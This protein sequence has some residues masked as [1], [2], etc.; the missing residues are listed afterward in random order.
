MIPTKG[1]WDTIAPRWDAILAD[2]DSWPNH[3]EAFRRFH[4]FLKRK[5]KI[6][7]RTQTFRLLDLA[8]GT[9]EASWPLWKRVSSVTFLDSSPAMLRMARNKWDKGVFVRGD[10]ADPPF[11]DME[12]DVIVSRGALL[13]QLDPVLIPSF[14]RHA[15][16]IL[17]L[18]GQ[19][20]FD[21]VCNP[22]GW[23]CGELFVS[24]WSRPQMEALLRQHLPTFKVVAYDGTPRHV[25]NRILLRKS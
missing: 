20:V 24:A 5:V 12:F 10:A 6:G 3:E 19:F 15:N 1:S 11:L 7:N 9:G 17:R 2:G 16:R 14:F 25:V 22:A 8:C 4:W 13:S 23:P 18:Q 21:F